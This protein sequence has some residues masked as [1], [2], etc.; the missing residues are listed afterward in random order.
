LY[1]R[2][3]TTCTACMPRDAPVPRHCQAESNVRRRVDN[4]WVKGMLDV[5]P[6]QSSTNW[7]SAHPFRWPL[8]VTILATGTESSFSHQLLLPKW[9]S[10]LI[11]QEPEERA[12]LDIVCRFVVL[13]GGCRVISGRLFIINQPGGN[14]GWWPCVWPLRLLVRQWSFECNEG[15]CYWTIGLVS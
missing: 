10:E 2:I 6:P 14:G 7:G 11:R 3:A 1:S 5:V 15:R 9:T 12:C 8:V 4:C 13:S